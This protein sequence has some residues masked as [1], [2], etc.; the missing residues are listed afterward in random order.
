[1]KYKYTFGLIVVT[2][3]VV[4]LGVFAILIGA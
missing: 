1:M 2:S 4:A 3:V